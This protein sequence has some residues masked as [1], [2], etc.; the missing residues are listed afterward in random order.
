M[1]FR[2]TRTRL[3]SAVTAVLAV[4]AIGAGTL[5]T[6]PAVSAAPAQATAETGALPVFPTGAQVLATGPSGFLTHDRFASD[7]AASTLLWTPYDGGAP[8]PVAVPDGGGWASAGGDVLVVGDAPSARDMRAV[9]LR[10][11]ADPAAPGVTF[12]LSSL[13]AS[14]VTVLGPTSVLAQVQKGDGEAELLVVTRNGAALDT[15]PVTGLPAHAQHFWSDAPIVNGQ[16]L[17]GHMASKSD[18]M[19]GGRSVIDI[20]SGTVVLTYGADEGGIDFSHLLFSESY[21]GWYERAGTAITLTTISRGQD[22]KRTTKLLSAAETDLTALAGD[23]LILGNPSAGVRAYS[24]S[25]GDSRPVTNGSGTTGLAAEG[26]DTSVVSGERPD[27]TR[28]LFRLGNAENGDLA[29]TKIADM[30]LGVPLAVVGSHVPA[31]VDLDQSGGKVALGWTLSRPDAT[32]VVTLTHI[33]TGKV[34]RQHLGPVTDGTSRFS[35][36]WSGEVFGAD[37]PHDDDAPNGAYTV[38]M[39]ATQVDAIGETVRDTRRM[40]LTRTPNPHDFTDNGSTDVLARDASGVLWRDD[41]RDRPVGGQTKT[42]QRARIGSG[43]NTY[44][45]IEAVGNIAGAAQGDLVGVDGSGVLWHYLGKGDGTF[46][47]RRQVGGGWQVYNKITGGSDLN[48]DG[49]ADLVATDTSGV[50]WFYAGTGDA[51][52]PYKKRVSLGGG[53]QVYNQITAVGDIAGAS[54]GD[55]VARDKDGVLWLYLGKGDGTFTARRQIGGGWQAYSQ[56][57]GAGDVDSDG[58][59]DL[60]AYGAGGTYVYKATGSVTTPFA[61]R[62]S[63]DLYAGEGTKFTNIS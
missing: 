43:W 36:D 20:A 19:A 61:P 58:R 55:L 50:L 12:D 6:A 46:T 13:N 52:Q 21:V 38:A 1:Q 30:E 47:A 33:A 49:R 56:L 28:G 4:T 54:G 27:G 31:T 23:W 7:A 9:T 53:W 42:A 5:A 63:T 29:V 25:S 26:D 15:A 2:T 40:E 44:K 45:H 37:A 17:V 8:T 51:A 18:P 16:V 59:P 3:A 34:F 32:M 11:M 14:Y 22:P 60:I 24:L 62:A 57:V 10:N 48:A 35:F 39:E 41:L